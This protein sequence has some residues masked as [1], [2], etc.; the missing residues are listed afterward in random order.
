M[1][2]YRGGPDS[3]QDQSI[4]ICGG[5]TGTGRDFSLSVL[6]THLH[7]HVALTRKDKVAKPRTFPKA[8][9]LAEIADHWIENFTFLLVSKG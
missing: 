4:E 1:S 8:N 3:I 2:S 6:H 5:Q 9:V 7:L